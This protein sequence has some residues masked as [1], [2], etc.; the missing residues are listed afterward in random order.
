M[1]IKTAAESRTD[2]AHRQCPIT[3]AA[4]HHTTLNTFAIIMQIL[5]GGTLYDPKC[6]STA[7]KIIKLCH[8]E[9]QRQLRRY[10]A[11]RASKGTPL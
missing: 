9:Q 11:A 2:M 3:Q 10:D 1:S 4:Y 7:R 8:D 6:H 5:E